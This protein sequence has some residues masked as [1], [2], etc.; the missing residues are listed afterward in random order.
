MRLKVL[1]LWFLLMPTLAVAQTFGFDD[2][3]QR[4][5]LTP[6]MEEAKAAIDAG[7]CG[8]AAVDFINAR[9]RAAAAFVVQGTPIAAQPTDTVIWYD[10]P[11]PAP[12]AHCGASKFQFLSADGPYAQGWEIG[13]WSPSWTQQPPQWRLNP[14][15]PPTP[16]YQPPALPPPVV[17]PPPAPAPAPVPSVDLQA[18]IAAAVAQINAHTD[19]AV[20]ADG[21]QTRAE[22]KTF[23]DQ[24]KAAFYFAAK[25]V[26]PAIGAWVAAKQTGK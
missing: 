22:L 23:G 2:S 4:Y 20:K 1:L 26:M 5:P 18:A 3:W 9:H 7:E 6:A 8:Q 19:A 11:L 16:G 24:A 17:T 14:F 13:L 21:D 12:W 15:A 25:Y 10:R